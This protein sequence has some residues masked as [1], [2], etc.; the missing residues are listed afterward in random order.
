MILPRSLAWAASLSSVGMIIQRTKRSEFREGESGMPQQRAATETLLRESADAERALIETEAAAERDLQR[1]E[2][3]YRR[4]LEKL[5][6]AQRR[7]EAERKS[8]EQAR[9]RLDQSQL[10]RAAGPLIR[11]VAVGRPTLPRPARDDSRARAR[12]RKMQEP[13]PEGAGP[14]GSDTETKV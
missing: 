12:A 13:A 14:N 7:V 5:E 2:E 1:A 10:E 6:R 11:P 8:F 9:A 3:R 4:A